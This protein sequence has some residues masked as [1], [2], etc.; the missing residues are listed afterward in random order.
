MSTPHYC[1]KG[2]SRCAHLYM[3]PCERKDYEEKQEKLNAESKAKSEAERKANEAERKANESDLKRLKDE[4][5]EYR[6]KFYAELQSYKDNNLNKFV[7]TIEN[8][9]AILNMEKKSDGKGNHII[10]QTGMLSQTDNV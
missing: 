3:T 9:A 2:C 8:L 4:E 1:L 7:S 5:R 6:D 10:S